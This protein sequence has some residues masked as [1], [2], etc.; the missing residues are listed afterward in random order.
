ALFLFDEAARLGYMRILETA[1][2]AGRKY[3]ISLVLL[4]QSLGQMREAFGGRD[5]TSKWFESA[6]W[7]SFSAINDT[8]TAH[9]V[10]QRCGTTTVE[11]AQISSTSKQLGASRTRSRQ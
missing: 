9:Y 1:R 7:V 3:G 6:S 4:F 10:S 2:D 5:A 11:V 8:D